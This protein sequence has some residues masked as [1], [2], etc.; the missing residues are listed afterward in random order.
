MQPLPTQRTSAD[1][2]T[3]TE[4]DAAVRRLKINEVTVPDDTPAEVYKYCP[5]IK[6]ELFNLLKFTWDNECL[7]KNLAVAEFKM[8]FKGKGSSDEPKKYRCIGLLN[9][10]YK[11]IANVIMARLLGCSEDFLAK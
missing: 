1:D 5:A 11:L 7:P 6:A 9:H 2:L 4:F 10:A 3:W 8:L